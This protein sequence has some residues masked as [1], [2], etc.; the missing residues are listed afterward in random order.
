MVCESDSPRGSDAG[1]LSLSQS[2]RGARRRGPR[3]PLPPARSPR[4]GHPRHTNA[5]PVTGGAFVVVLVLLLGALGG[6]GRGTGGGGLGV[7]VVRGLRRTEV[8]VELVHERDARR[9]V[10]ARDVVVRDAVEVLHERA[11]RVAVRRDEDGLAS[12]QVLRDVRL[13]VRQEAVDDELQRLG[14]GQLVAEVGV[15]AVPGLRPLGVVGDGGG[16]TSNER[17][18]SMNCCSPYCS[19]V[20]A[21]SLP[22]RSP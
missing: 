2:G 16:G 3:P 4:S 9:D 17:R 11:E 18:H 22:C 19:S 8:V 6:H 15:A 1:R 5:P 14:T 12:A 13:P 20:W 21:L 10:Q 7:E